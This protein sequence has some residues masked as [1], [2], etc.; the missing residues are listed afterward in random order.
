MTNFN[1]YLTQQMKD[2]A[3]KEAYEQLERLAA[4]LGK[5]LKI[6]FV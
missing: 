4:A 1:D 5:T 6:E 3:F 2:S